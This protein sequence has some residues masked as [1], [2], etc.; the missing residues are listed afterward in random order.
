MKESQKP[1]DEDELKAHSDWSAEILSWNPN[2]EGE[3]LP[4]LYSIIRE[5]SPL[6]R[7]KSIAQS[8]TP[9]EMFAALV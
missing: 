3:E 8:Y 5:D 1:Q 9:Q 2:Y 7:I 6:D 4:D